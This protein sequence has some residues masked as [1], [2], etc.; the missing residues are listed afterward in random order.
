VIDC[1]SYEALNL[2]NDRVAY[3]A[4][5]GCMSETSKELLISLF[6]RSSKGCSFVL[7]LDNDLAG[8]EM[9][10]KIQKL[11]DEPLERIKPNLKDWNEDLNDLKID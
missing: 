6:K 2:S 10:K 5:G 9:C 11:S 4:L 7:A 3:I 8:D 1:L